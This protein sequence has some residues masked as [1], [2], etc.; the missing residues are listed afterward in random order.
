MQALADAFDGSLSLVSP[1]TF[2]QRMSDN[3]TQELCLSASPALVELWEL[4]ATSFNQAIAD[5]INGTVSP[6]RILQPPT[7]TGK[8][9]GAQIYSAMQA[10]L[11]RTL[12]VEQRVGILIVTR[13]IE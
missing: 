1:I 3:W 4:M 9:T 5:T 12:P 2:T 6:W 10:Q 11:N 8:T 7:G 13:L